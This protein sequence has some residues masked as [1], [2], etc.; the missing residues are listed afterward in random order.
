MPV[1]LADVTTANASRYLQ[2]LCKHWSH[3]FEVKFDAHTG[4]VPFNET[5]QLVLTANGD[6][7]SLR[8]DAPAERLQTLEQVVEDHLKRFAF[9]EELHFEWR[10][11]A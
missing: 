4:T 11:A 6:I 7:L 8:L 1:S 5:A 2:Q 9:R 3:K 10:P